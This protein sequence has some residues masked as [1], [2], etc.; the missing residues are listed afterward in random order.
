[1]LSSEA[2]DVIMLLRGLHHRGRAEEGEHIPAWQAIKLL[3]RAGVSRE[4]WLFH[5]ENEVY[6]LCCGGV[7]WTRNPPRLL[8]TAKLE[9]WWIPSWYQAQPAAI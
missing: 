7:D 1:M 8:V 2:L 9:S 5:R 3:Y 4:Q 6:R